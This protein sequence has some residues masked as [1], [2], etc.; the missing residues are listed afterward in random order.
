VV[1]FE[2][3]ATYDPPRNNAL[4]GG[5]Y[6]L[7]R[8]VFG[9][10]AIRAETDSRAPTLANILN[11]EHHLLNRKTPIS[12]SVLWLSYLMPCKPCG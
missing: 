4:S 1:S 5:F 12:P 3:F 10:P 7:L 6:S 9:R 2:F 8:G 11:L